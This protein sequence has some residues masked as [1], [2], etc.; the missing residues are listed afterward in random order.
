MAAPALALDFAQR[1]KALAGATAGVPDAKVPL[2]ASGSGVIPH[3]GLEAAERVVARETALGGNRDAAL[4]A[5]AQREDLLVGLAALD[6]DALEERIATDTPS[7]LAVLDALC[8]SP[9]TRF[10]EELAWMH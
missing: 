1:V 8:D 7:L 9:R 2:K 10:A 5:L 6:A 4:M 3:V